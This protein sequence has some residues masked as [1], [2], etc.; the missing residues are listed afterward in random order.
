MMSRSALDRNFR[1][2]CRA[3]TPGSTHFSVFPVQCSTFPEQ[4]RIFW[5]NADLSTPIEINQS[6]FRDKAERD[7]PN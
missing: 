4:E 7:S 5:T 2:I 6:P 1:S 3:L